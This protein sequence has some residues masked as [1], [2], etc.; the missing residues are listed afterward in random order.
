MVILSKG[1]FS[2]HAH[3]ER[4]SAFLPVTMLVSCPEKGIRVVSHTHVARRFVRSEAA[5]ALRRSKV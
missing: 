4:H 2:A 3:E 5:K 1:R